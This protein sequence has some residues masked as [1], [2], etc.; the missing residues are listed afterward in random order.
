MSSDL[1]GNIRR[2]LFPHLN[3][4]APHPIKRYRKNKILY[5]AKKKMVGEVGLEPTKA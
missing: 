5:G 3:A 1:R 2:V 4:D